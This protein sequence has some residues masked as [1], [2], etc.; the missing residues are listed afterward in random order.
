MEVLAQLELDI[1]K[2]LLSAWMNILLLVV[3]VAVLIF[4]IRRSRKKRIEISPPETIPCFSPTKIVKRQIYLP[5][6]GR[7]YY[8]KAT[9]ESPG[10]RKATAEIYSPPALT[11][12]P[13]LDNLIKI[14]GDSIIFQSDYLRDDI[15]IE[16]MMHVLER[17][18]QRRN[19]VTNPK[20]DCFADSQNAHDTTIVSKSL[21]L[22]RKL[23][24]QQPDKIS[25][26]E[27]ER[28]FGEAKGRF[29]DSSISK[30]LDYINSHD[31]KIS[32]ISESEKVVFAKLWRYINSLQDQEKKSNLLES[33]HGQLKDSIDKD[34]PVCVIGRFNRMM[35]TF[36]GVDESLGTHWMAPFEYIKRE[37][38]DR[39]G[40]LW[41]EVAD[42]DSEIAKSY[43]RDTLRKEYVDQGIITEEK[44]NKAT[45]WI[46]CL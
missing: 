26:E 24:Q 4:F 23:N 22:W 36:L 6:E 7:I 38:I 8:R 1:F 3:T 33:L 29:N 30:L 45:D 31:A 14:E 37:L 34:L 20:K 35:S 19:L 11:V 13:M 25:Q 15:P 17:I 21:Q 43:V 46:D 5:V 39:G 41:K 44:F 18:P 9:T 32:A 16:E 10:Y 27:I 28:S 2:R 40:V 12:D 42:K